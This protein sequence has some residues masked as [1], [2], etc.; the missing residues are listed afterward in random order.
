[1][2]TLD[3]LKPNET[4]F[5]TKININDNYRRRLLYLGFVN[6]SK[7]TSLYKSPSGNPTAYL[8]KGAVI[9]IREEDAKKI[10]IYRY[11]TASS[12]QMKLLS[13]NKKCFLRES[14]VVLEWKE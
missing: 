9:A 4:A 2:Y 6:G 3:K 5:I 1:M 12:Q 7:I 14:L 8:I 10:E 11:L 13:E